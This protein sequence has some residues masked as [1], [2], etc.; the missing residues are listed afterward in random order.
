M[1]TVEFIPDDD[2][3]LSGRGIAKFA[4]SPGTCTVRRWNRVIEQDGI[5]FIGH[6]SV[7]RNVFDIA[8]AI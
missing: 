7:F 5:N 6:Q 8:P 1:S 2:D 4:W 3:V